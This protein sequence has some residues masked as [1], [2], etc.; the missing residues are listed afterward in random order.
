M[1]FQLTTWNVLHRIHAVN[2]NEAPVVKFPDE[3]VRI[4]GITDFIATHLFPISTAIALQE[5]SGDQLASVRAAFEAKATILTHEYPRLPKLKQPSATTP[6]SNLKE[7]LVTIVP[8]PRSTRVIESETY[9]SDPGKGFLSTLIDDKLLVIN[10]H[11]SAG[12]RRD[13]QLARLV[14][15]TS[16]HSA[17]AT[18]GD[19]N[20]EHDLLHAT[21]LTLAEAHSIMGGFTLTD[22]SAQPVTRVGS[23]GK[24]GHT[25]DHVISKH[26]LT[27]EPGTVID[28]GG[29]S[30]HQPVTARIAE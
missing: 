13:K 6:L 17:V 23:P 11:V 20:T 21:L 14:R 15:A 26:P 18:L 16:N 3:R 24:S 28:A 12:G 29:L 1:M 7:Y 19:F 5:V 8:H 4:A 30:D 27:I 25:I 9:E 10:T 22:L 2:W